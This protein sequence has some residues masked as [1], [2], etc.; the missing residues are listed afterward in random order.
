M[1]RL[2]SEDELFDIGW[3][4]Y[5]QRGGVIAVEWGERAENAFPSGTV[6][7][8]ITKTGENSRTVDIEYPEGFS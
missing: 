2:K 7:V 1:Y 5:L 6:R 4:D 8:K 3:E